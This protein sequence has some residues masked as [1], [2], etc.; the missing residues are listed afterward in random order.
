LTSQVLAGDVHEISTDCFAYICSSNDSVYGGFGANQA[1]LLLEESVLVFDTGIS[2]VQARNLYRAIRRMSDKKI[3]YLVNSHDHSD[4]VFGNS[5]FIKK[6]AGNCPTIMSHEIC[7]DNLSKLGPARLRNYRKIPDMEKPLESLQVMEPNFTYSDLG[8]RL[9]IEGTRLVMSHPPT[10]AHTLGDTILFLPQKGVVFAGDI[11]WNRFLPNL[12]DANLEGWI[13]FLEDIDFASYPKVVPGHGEVCGGKRVAEFA[14]YLKAV[15][16]NILKT[17]L[18]LVKQANSSLLG[19][20]FEVP[21]SE[22]WK[23]RPIVDH[24][25]NA[26]FLKKSGS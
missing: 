25:V 17:D 5:F 22:H 19:K 7:R 11:V 3:R 9:E 20:C 8:V 2:L 16:E 12:E 10:G 13:S 18:S 6:S 4:H 15:Q 1:F 21:G 23:L 24:N 26:L 14:D